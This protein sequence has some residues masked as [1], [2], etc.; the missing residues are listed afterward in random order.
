MHW[1]A[2]HADRPLD[3]T[4]TLPG[5]KSM[6]NRA[7]ILAAPAAGDVAFDGDPHARK[8]PMGP[9]LGAL[10]PLGVAIDGDALPFTV[11]GT[12]SV[13][14]GEVENVVM[15]GKTLPDFIDLWAGMWGGS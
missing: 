9:I 6:T 11:H 1:H 15:V 10:G 8:R 13:P 5:S 12:G 4:V 14:G 7:L 2:P 3:A